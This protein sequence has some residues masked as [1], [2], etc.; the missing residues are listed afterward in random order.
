M[1]RR[2]NAFLIFGFVLLSN[3]QNTMLF[4][5]CRPIDLSVSKQ[6]VTGVHNNMYGLFPVLNIETQVKKLAS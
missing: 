4:K 6:G 1:A 2:L 3:V 5:A